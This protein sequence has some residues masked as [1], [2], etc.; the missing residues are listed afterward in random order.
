MRG[1]SNLFTKSGTVLRR[2]GKH[3][4][5]EIHREHEDVK[6]S[7]EEAQESIDS[8]NVKCELHNMK[9]ET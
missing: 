3:E 7:A 9:H 1:T 5:V 6:E 8:R 2:T 4:I